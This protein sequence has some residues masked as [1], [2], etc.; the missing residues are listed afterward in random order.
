VATDIE[1]LPARYTTV[2][3]LLI[4]RPGIGAFVAEPEVGD[5][6]IGP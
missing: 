2:V 6:E 1:V 3:E 5:P 4:E